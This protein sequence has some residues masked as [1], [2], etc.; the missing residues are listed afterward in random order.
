[1]IYIIIYSV[2]WCLSI[3]VNAL[4]KRKDFLYNL[5]LT[6]LFFTVVFF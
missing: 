5:Y 3:F 2:G 6:H 4:S 1:M